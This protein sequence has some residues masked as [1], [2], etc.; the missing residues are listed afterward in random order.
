MTEQNKTTERLMTGR[1][2]KE[3]VKNRIKQQK[4]PTEETA[5]K[6]QKKTRSKNKAGKTLSRHKIKKISE[7]V[8]NVAV[9]YPLDLSSKIY[10]D[11]MKLTEEEEKLWKDAVGDLVEE[12]NI[13]GFNP[14]LSLTIVAVSTL[15]PRGL[16]VYNCHKAARE[17]ESKDK[18]AHKKPAEKKPD[19]PNTN[20]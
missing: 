19:A 20:K 12:L 9:S 6:P 16:H 15:A 13:T 5:D 4:A 8:V 18:T 2:G 11:V 1:E 3:T 10:G 14:W 17:I 7:K